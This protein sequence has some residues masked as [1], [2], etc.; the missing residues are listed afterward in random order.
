MRSLI[1]VS[2]ITIIEGDLSIETEDYEL[3]ADVF[4]T[5]GLLERSV[6]RKAQA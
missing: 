1:F 5:V 6:S 3:A 4:A 2:V